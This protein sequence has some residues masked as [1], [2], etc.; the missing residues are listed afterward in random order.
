LGIESLFKLFVETVDTL[1]K[2]LNLKS[3]RCRGPLAIELV[4]ILFLAFSLALF[5]VADASRLIEI[6]YISVVVMILS[7]VGM[8]TLERL[9]LPSDKKQ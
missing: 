1:A 4:I 2:T 5:V 6:F 9:D 3:V 8:F 7:F